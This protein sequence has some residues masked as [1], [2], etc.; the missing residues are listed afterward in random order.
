MITKDSITARRR[1]ATAELCAIGPALRIHHRVDVEVSRHLVRGQS[2]FVIKDPVSLRFHQLNQ[3]EHF[4]WEQLDGAVSMEEICSRFERRFPA[5]RLTPLE[6]EQFVGKLHRDG[7]VVAQATEQ[8]SVLHERSRTSQRLQHL[9]R[10]ANPLAIRLPSFNPRALFDF[11]EPLGKWIFSPAVVTLG[12]LLIATCVLLAAIQFSEFSLRL[13]ETR[14][15]SLAAP[16]LALSLLK[17]CHELGHGMLCRRQGRECH[18]MGAMLLFFTPCVYCN[19][20]DS[21][22]LPS[23]WQRAGVA[24]VGVWVELLLASCFGLLWW[25]SE[26]GWF[27]QFAACVM[28]IGSINSLLLNGNPLLHFDGYYVLADL[29]EYPNLGARSQRVLRDAAW[30]ALLGI[31]PT[32]RETAEDRNRLLL[33]GLSATVYRLFLIAALITAA[34]WFLKPYRMTALLLALVLPLAILPLQRFATRV[35]QMLK[36][37]ATRIR[38]RHLIVTGTVFVLLACLACVPLP[39]KVRATGRVRF[40]NERFIRVAVPGRITQGIAEGE[41]VSQG[42][43]VA[44]LEND[45]LS[46]KLAELQEEQV[47]LKLQIEELQGMRQADPEATAKVPTLQEQLAG[48]ER[49]ISSQQMD[50]DRL[51]VLAPQD[52]IVVAPPTTPRRDEEGE[53]PTWSGTPLRPENRGCY[54]ERGEVL[55]ILG[56]PQSMS[57][58]AEVEPAT[59]EQIEVGQAASAWVQGTAVRGQVASI[60]RLNPQTHDEVANLRGEQQTERPAS[61]SVLI[62][63]DEPGLFAPVGVEVQV[64]IATPPASILNRVGRWMVRTFRLRT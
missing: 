56:D 46:R 30:Q 48:V 31:P 3:Q 4:L 55:A 29:W 49:E 19:V 40:L 6:L 11:L 9:Q 26:P 43:V 7:L 59:V 14:M 50:V 28:L 35:N 1:Q 17:A 10:F 41:A 62:H 60:S 54:L 18:E 63:L 61:Y 64:K 53:L 21:W 13:A 57:I 36:D 25:F 27:H 22:M 51:Q 8:G 45:E 58:M 47:Q 34:Y 20:T 44:R 16:L 23:K 24:A 12:C 37:P 5:S 33:Y 38:R 42:T 15:G 39:R 32:H 2:Q 52:G